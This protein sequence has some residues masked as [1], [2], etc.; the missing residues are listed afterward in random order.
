MKKICAAILAMLLVLG[1]FTAC[2]GA[3]DEVN[4]EILG[5]KDAAA[6]EQGK[7][8][9]ALAG[10]TATDDKDGD[11]TAKIVITSTPA[12]EFVNGKTTPTKQGT[13]ELVYSVKD[14]AGNEGNTYTTLTVTRS[15]S[16]ETSYKKYQFGNTDTSD[17]DDFGMEL[18]KS[19][20][21]DATLALTDGV[22]R[23]DVKNSG[24]AVGDVKLMRQE[25]KPV[26]GTEYDVIFTMKSSQNIM[27]NMLANHN[28]KDGDTAAWAPIGSS[29]WNVAMGSK[30]QEY[31]LTFTVPEGENENVQL[32]FELGKHSMNDV[33][34]PDSYVVDI[35]YVKV[36]ERVGEEYPESVFKTDFTAENPG[37]SMS[38]TALGS[39][40]FANGKAVATIT[41]Y[42]E[43]G[44]TNKLEQ[45]TTVSLVKDKKYRL[46]LKMTAKNA[47]S[48]E[49]CIEDKVKEWEIRALYD[50]I[51]LAAGEEVVYTKDFISTADLENACMKFYVGGASA[52]V[53]SNEITVT[54]WEISELV[55][56]KSEDK[57][58]YRFIPYSKASEW[59]CFNGRESDIG[60]GMGTMYEKDGSMF[61]RVDELSAL[62]YGNKIFVNKITLEKDALY[63]I[64]FTIKANKAGKTWFILN[65]LD[66][67]KFEPTVSEVCNLTTEAQTFEFTTDREFPLA[68]DFELVWSFGQGYNTEGDYLIEISNV[69][70]L[71][72]T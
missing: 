38:N 35:L 40:A 26:A 6:V 13:Y 45:D 44:W 34:N 47:Q 37:M 10:V 11:L 58:L 39:V 55:G 46:T 68:L 18:I 1:V 23:L 14:K 59:D 69:E 25:F 12:L 60:S 9:D 52:G 32:I 5:V 28:T 15:I 17:V 41:G 7:E 42:G 61:Y 16:E 30:Y 24:A 50:N 43:A 54:E 19:G 36:V 53:T 71:K 51:N 64:R 3:K 4:P 62:D 66:T 70:I 20:T 49:F 31:K 67:S 27:F 65:Q 33:S 2:S 63:K 56:D 48:G 29:A 21:G 57:A 72:L 8:Y 22:M